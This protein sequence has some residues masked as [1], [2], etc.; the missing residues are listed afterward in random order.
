MLVKGRMHAWH[1][2]RLYTR[3]Y[4][5]SWLYE[6]MQ[7][8]GCCAA[9]WHALTAMG[10]PAWGSVAPVPDHRAS[11]LP[12]PALNIGPAQPASPFVATNRYCLCDAC[13]T[14]IEL[15]ISC[16]RQE[17]MWHRLTLSRLGL[18]ARSSF[19]NSSPLGVLFA[20]TAGVI[21]LS[22]H[23][24]LAVPALHGKSMSAPKIRY[25]HKISEFLPKHREPI[26][27]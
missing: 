8:H 25:I 11:E 16:L 12:T 6:E 18:S 21:T 15:K 1:H 9:L 22:S 27:S 24:G 2:L 3:K 10:A 13:F 14:V 20:R 19:G 7:R 26:K 4:A 17:Q 5:S 23:A